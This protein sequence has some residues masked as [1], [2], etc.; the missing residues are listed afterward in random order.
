MPPFIFSEFMFLPVW[1][2]CFAL[3]FSAICRRNG[4]CLSLG[5]AKLT[6]TCFP[7]SL[8]CQFLG[9]TG[10]IGPPD[11]ALR[12]KLLMGYW[13]GPSVRSFV[14]SVTAMCRRLPRNR[15]ELELL[16]RDLVHV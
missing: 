2:C 11:I 15:S 13:N 4:R 16:S 12:S 10:T 3:C 1:W 14:G 5:F 9:R 8:S 7:A 6:G